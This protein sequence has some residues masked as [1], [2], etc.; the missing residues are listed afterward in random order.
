MKNGVY[1]T[2]NCHVKRVK[3]LLYT[4]SSLLINPILIAGD[5]KNVSTNGRV[6]GNI[7]ELEEMTV[8]ATRREKNLMDT[9]VSISAFDQEALIRYGVKDARDLE[10][11]VPTLK[12]GIDSEA[13]AV[14]FYMRGVGSTNNTELGDPNVGFHVD[15]VYS[16]R[17]QGAMALLYDLERLEILRGPQGTLFGRNS[18]VG[19]INV[20]TAKPNLN[21]FEVSVNSEIGNYNHYQLRSMVNIPVSDD[22]AI[23]GNYIV[24][25]RDGFVDQYFDPN[26]DQRRNKEVDPEDYYLNSDSYAVRVS[27]LWA[28]AEQFTWHFSYETFQDQGAGGVDLIDCDQSNPDCA[29]GVET[30]DA[31]VNI[32]GDLDF[33]IDSIR[34]TVTFD[35]NEWLQLSY[36][37][38]YADQERHHVMDPRITYIA[39][40]GTVAGDDVYVATELSDYE[41]VSNEFQLKSIGDGPM[42]WILG[43]FS[44]SEENEIRFDVDFF[45]GGLIFLQ[46]ERLLSSEAFYGQGTYS[47]AERLRLTLGYRTTKDEKEDK[48]GGNYSAFDNDYFKDSDG[49][50]VPIGQRDSANAPAYGTFV[51]PN[52]GWAR[53][54]DN[55]IKDSWS[56]DTYRVGLDVDLDR[57]TLL[58]LSYA[59]GFKAGGFGDVIDHP[60]TGERTAFNYDPEEIATW[61]IGIKSFLLEDRLRLSAAAFVSDY[62]DMQVTTVRN[63]GVDPNTGRNIE[64]L[65]TENAAESTI[66]GLELEFDYKLTSNSR[67]TGFVT[68]LD[69]TIDKWVTKDDRFCQRFPGGTCSVMDLSGNSLTHAPEWSTT[70]TYEYKFVMDTG[71]VVTP[72]V[73]LHL[74]D[75]YYLRV[76]N[77]DQKGFSDRQDS[78][79]NIDVSLRYTSPQKNWSVE[80]YGKNVT[81]ELVKNR[82]KNDADSTIIK[83]AYN[84]P[85]TYGIRLGYVW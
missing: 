76:W 9:P 1:L 56:K 20:I 12:L 58:Y 63:F 80:L 60:I 83:G 52:G 47:I 11:W 17:P 45:T 29:S 38:G 32:P 85:G 34:S 70:I 55:S 50:V 35:I 62:T 21:D 28:P 4:I 40:D 53:D 33:T 24:D 46:P 30:W 59:T 78:W 13:N 39:A 49:N 16:P 22:F 43:Y 26:G 14:E 25:K 61:E 18:T 74:E 71:G 75:E 36:N 23:R 51:F 15:G 84:A 41:S 82:F 48:D 8:T 57:H 73:S 66:N 68:L 2:M 37:F 72:F 64:Q 6:A 5:D 67:L 79:F 69:A 3:F 44:F 77:V 31:G 19:V 10:N 65:I 54:T 27:T 81:D 7:H 42:E